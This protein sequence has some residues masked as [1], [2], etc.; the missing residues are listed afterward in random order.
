MRCLK[1]PYIR[2]LLLLLFLVKPPQ[3]FCKY[4]M[5]Y[6]DTN[7]FAVL[8]SRLNVSSTN[9]EVTLNHSPGICVDQPNMHISELHKTW[10][11]QITLSNPTTNLLIF[12]Q[13]C[14]VGKKPKVHLPWSSL[15]WQDVCDW[16]WTFTWLWWRR[17]DS[18]D[19]AFFDK[20]KSAFQTESDYAVHMLFVMLFQVR[21]DLMILEK[22]T[23]N[24]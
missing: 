8:S 23:P 15:G 7:P 5:Y 3:M 21:A 16:Q 13:Y 20:V 24:F 14:V 11:L 18:G 19:L 10:N 2:I 17:E 22:L 4:A 9:Y 1:R 6:P 12:V